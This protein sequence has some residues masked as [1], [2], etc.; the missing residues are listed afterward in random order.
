M[1]GD[2]STR[3][4]GA[5]VRIATLVVVAAGSAAAGFFGVVALAGG[6]RRARGG[7]DASVAPPAEAPDG[8]R[9]AADAGPAEEA[10]AAPG[11]RVAVGEPFYFRCWSEADAGPLTEGQ[12]GSLPPLERLV[13]SRLELA[14]RCRE[15]SSQPVAEGVVS[16][17]VDADFGSGRLR[18][19]S[20]PSSTL[21][22]AEEV[23]SCIRRGFEDVSIEPMRHRLVR[24]TIFFPISYGAE[25]EAEA[26]P[27]DGGQMVRLVLDRV[28]LRE[29]PERGRIMARLRRGELVTIVERR[30]GWIRVRTA[31]GREGWVFE[32][33]ITGEGGEEG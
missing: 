1:G 19:W 26:A 17:G 3:S 28:R 21:T 30:E 18:L 33:A 29:S 31:D 32:P 15:Q 24:Y 14:E 4:R 27:A 6:A 7:E 16:L 20:G 5:W 9:E 13:A 12:C 11:G 23:V 2:G 25:A 10:P 22:N 8:D